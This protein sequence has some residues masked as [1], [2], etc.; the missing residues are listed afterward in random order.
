MLLAQCNQFG[1]VFIVRP[2][3]QIDGRLVNDVRS[4]KVGKACKGATPSLAGRFEFLCSGPIIIH[5]TDHMISKLWTIGDLADK[6]DRPVVGSHDE[7]MAG[8]SSSAPQC[9]KQPT[10][11][12][13]T[14]RHHKGA[15]QPEQYD[16]S[17]AYNLQLK[18]CGRRK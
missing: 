10:S 11:C 16:K 6:L 8:V 5:K 1:R 3:R 12:N 9:K 14:S 2:Q 13:P 18:K 15:Q 7:N 4:E 17:C